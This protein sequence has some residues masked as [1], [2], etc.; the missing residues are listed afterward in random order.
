MSRVCLLLYSAT[1]SCPIPKDNSVGSVGNGGK[2][3]KLLD[4]ASEDSEAIDAG[5]V[6]GAAEPGLPLRVVRKIGGRTGHT[7]VLE[8]RVTPLM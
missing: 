2:V 4:Q 1:G 8:E 3:H 6:S 7:S 5:I